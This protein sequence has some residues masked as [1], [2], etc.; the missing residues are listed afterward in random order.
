VNLDGFEAILYPHVGDEVVPAAD[1][2]A[3]WYECGV[4]CLLACCFFLIRFVLLFA[5]R[6]FFFARLNFLFFSRSVVSLVPRVTL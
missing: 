6:F 2:F 4:P 3:F 5:I 1:G